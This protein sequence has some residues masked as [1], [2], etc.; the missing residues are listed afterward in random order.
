MRFLKYLINKKVMLPVFFAVA[1]VVCGV[2]ARPVEVKAANDFP[3]ITKL[4]DYS[5]EGVDW[6]VLYNASD[7][8]YPYMC[9]FYYNDPAYVAKP[10]TFAVREGVEDCISY[11][12]ALGGNT[13]SSRPCYKYN[14]ESGQWARFYDC[15]ISGTLGADRY[16]GYKEAPWMRG[17]TT[18]KGSSVSI[19]KIWKDNTR[20]LFF[21]ATRQTLEPTVQSLDLTGVMREIIGL[22]PLLVV[23]VVCCLGLKKCLRWLW[24][25]SRRA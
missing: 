9:V 6:I 15:N 23:L 24:Q 18:I 21:P 3:S 13:T 1:L 11:S 10:M 12:I 2:L 19:Y 22:I 20:K 5:F 25:I 4:E 8:V 7:T 14:A 16:S 17:Y